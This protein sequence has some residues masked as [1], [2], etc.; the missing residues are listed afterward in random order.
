M[1]KQ[2]LGVEMTIL[3][4]GD[5]TNL[6]KG[7]ILRRFNE[8]RPLIQN[9][10]DTAL[11]QDF[12][13]LK[14]R[15]RTFDFESYTGTDLPKFITSMTVGMLINQRDHDGKR[16]YERGSMADEFIRGLSE[17]MNYMIEDLPMSIRGVFDDLKSEP[18]K[19]ITVTVDEFMNA[20]GK[21]GKQ[22]V[23]DD[24]WKVTGKRPQ[25]PGPTNAGPII[26]P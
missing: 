8:G 3:S 7:M 16:L 25:N 26:I 19:S 20:H 24:R 4:S 2:P 5:R 11:E 13:E 14:K 23:E 22:A 21:D 15:F 9:Q 6:M 17:D 18:E 12:I 10:L 1:K